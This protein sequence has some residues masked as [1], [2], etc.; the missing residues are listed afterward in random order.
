MVDS[1]NPDINEVEQSQL[2]AL[3]LLQ[4]LGF[5]YV[6]RAQAL[7]WRGGKE[8][9]LLLEPVLTKALKRINQ[10]T[11]K[12]VQR[13]FSDASI[14]KAVQ[15]LKDVSLIQG[16]QKAN[17]S[18]YDL[19]TLPPSFDEKIDSDTKAFSLK[20]IDWSDWKNNDFHVTAEFSVTRSGR[21]D[22]FRCDIVVFVNGIPLAVIENKPRDKE[23]KDAVTQI[24]D[25]QRAEGI[26]ELFKY[27]QIVVG[28][29]GNDATYA[30]AGTPPKFWSKW[31]AETGTDE[32]V[33]GYIRGPLT[34]PQAS[35]LFTDFGEYRGEYFQR[36]P[37]MRE[38]TE[39][40]RTIFHLLRPEKLLRMVRRYIVFD[41][42]LKKI[43]RYQQVRAVEKAL[44]R[45]TVPDADGKRL[46]GVVG[47]TQGS[48]K[49]LTMVMLAK[50]IADDPKIVNER[51]ILVTDRK[52]L[53]KQIKGT[54]EACGIEVTRATTG[55]D[56]REKI[57]SGKSWVITSVINKFS[58]ALK[59][60]KFSDPS[61]N[62]F[63]L[64]DEGH[65]SQHGPM[66]SRIRQ[67]FP[68]ACYIGFTGTPLLKA[69]KS[70][71]EKF[72]GS[73]DVYSI[74]QAT[75]DKAV[76][77]LRYEGRLVEQEVKGE[78]LDKWFERYS[79]GLNDQ[80]RA[81]LKKK[82]SRA[83]V[84]PQT[85]PFVRL[86]AW[87]VYDH[88]KRNW[89]GTGFKAMLVA[90][91]KETAILFK[92]YL[93]HFTSLEADREPITCEVLISGPG[94]RE[95]EDAPDESTNKRVQAFWKQRMA[96]YEDEDDYND[97]V[98]DR[99]RDSDDIDILIVVSKLLTGFDAPKATVLYVAKTLKEHTLLQ[100]I[101]RVNRL[102]E[103]K[104]FGYI[105]DYMGNLG[106]LN[107]ALGVYTAL[108][109][110]EP[111]D[112]RDAVL[113]VRAEI[114]K[115][116]QR[117]AAL[118]SVFKDCPN[119]NDSESMEQWLG[120]EARREEFKE[121]L[122]EFGKNLHLALS[123]QT[124][125]DDVADA[126]IQR[127]QS[128][129]KNFI[130]LRGS[131]AL[132]YQEKVDFKQLEPQIKKLL[133]EYVDAKDIVK[134]QE[135]VDILDNAAIEQALEELGTSAAKADMIASVT[136]KKIEAEL[137]DRDPV[138]YQR[139][140]K[141]LQD[142]ID[143][144]RARVL[145]EADQV[146]YLSKV[147]G[148]AKAVDAGAKDEIP[149]PLKPRETAQAYYRVL[150]TWALGVGINDDDAIVALTLAVEAA[151]ESKYRVDWV[152]REDVK[153]QMRVEIDD[154]LYK[155]CKERDLTLDFDAFDQL[156]ETILTVAAKRRP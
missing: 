74:R 33:L 85:Q 35:Q 97:S 16:Q 32:E 92:E 86:V 127:Y 125:F 110:Y 112:V 82:W 49:S 48:G 14:A 126:D 147:Q 13:G 72:G 1:I 155:F 42:G 96:E 91:R 4:K 128:D 28:M 26:P 113:D 130:K 148:V 45:L 37:T 7:E 119:K 129:L 27:I 61:G 140:S 124:F 146:A 8:R 38:I 133:D 87:D 58:T 9:G 36:N 81:D 90:A 88:F 31:K 102:E 17:E 131:V 121:R 89:K 80:Q 106:H 156:A 141:M 41:A 15:M 63:V 47:H 116:P 67:V 101:A 23:L 95:D 10:F 40:D 57:Q 30:T 151:I 68:N 132:R 138:L 51:V 94:D 25:Y 43:A 54:F 46:G 150:G 105:I 73:I 93:E 153:N 29:K 6:R 21:A 139:F 52:D 56:L 12:G 135:E 76:V 62:I 109:G 50:A 84:L 136:K 18:V 142:V 137:K 98:R 19:L 55:A 70:T 24:R 2:P 75:E 134:L 122:R 11:Y 108:E 22:T 115:L 152:K 60:A 64:V 69:E 103:G 65:R 154:A 143:E 117:H 3:V 5:E 20:Y 99:F 53:D 71:F 83:D 66:H 145:T 78:P 104:E 39:Q 107:A 144:F 79:S 118:L 114:E 77:P 59:Q 149:A 120:D 100:A 111:D 44:S 34:T 123:T